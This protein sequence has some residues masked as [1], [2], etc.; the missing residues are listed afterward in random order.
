MKR[1]KLFL[2]TA[3]A[4]VLTASVSLPV[5]AAGGTY[6]ITI[7]NSAS[8]HTY[9]AYQI[10]TGTL[11]T[12]E[13]QTVLTDVTWGS[14]IQSAQFLEALK[15]DGTIGAHYAACTTAA[16]VAQA[17]SD[18]AGDAEA[19]AALA[20]D[21]LSS[22]T[23]TSTPGSG[24]YTIAGLAPGYYLVKDQDG[25][26]VDAYTSYILKLVG[27]VTVTPKS[28]VPTSQKKVKDI[29]DSTQ[30][31]Y[32]G[33]Q[34]SADHDIGDAIP[35][36]ISA[37]LPDNYDD[38]TTYSMTFHDTQSSGLTFNPDSV[39]V[40]VG[41]EGNTIDSQYYE[42]NAN[43]VDDCTFEIV[44]ENLK[45]V[46]GVTINPGSTIYVEYTSTLNENAVLG[47]AGNPNTMHLTYSNN[48]NGTGTGQTPDDKVIVFTYQVVVNKV[49]PE[50]MPLAGAQFTLEKYDADS[51]DWTSVGEATLSGEDTTFTFT[52]L[53]DGQYRLTET[54]TPAGYNTIDPIT[55]T[56]TA[57]HDET[58]D[59]PQLTSLSGNADTGTI[60]FTPALPTGS[61]TTNV[62]NEAGAV[63]PSTGG[64]GTTV[65]YVAGAVLVLGAGAC[66]VLRQIKRK[67]S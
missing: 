32:T 25:T 1:W 37:T 13:E 10:F 11:S 40:Y 43:P 44:F 3:L 56:V 18:N 66:L 9:E 47:S 61:L 34:D 12:V 54:Q 17:L 64:M 6:T 27:D 48:P 65:F 49:D 23:G 63:L 67:R 5:L 19:F 26:T 62:V 28:D 58:S 39:T 29:D 50:N 57:A 59:N 55:F 2:A 41:S 31:N 24:T 36:Q 51:A 4:L 60:T 46:S 16:D 7:Q 8:G 21:Y 45:A 35:F 33:W 38:Y 20:G 14:G 52:G 53:D 15:A 30:T 42:V 22:P